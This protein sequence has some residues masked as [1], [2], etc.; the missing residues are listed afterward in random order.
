M[1]DVCLKFLKNRERLPSIDKIKAGY[2]LAF[3]EDRI[4][5][6]K[7]GNEWVIPKGEIRGGKL[8]KKAFKNN[9][10]E[11]YALSCEDAEPYIILDPKKSEGLDVFFISDSVDLNRE[12]SLKNGGE[13]LE[14]I[15]IE[16]ILFQPDIDGDK[17]LLWIL[18]QNARAK[19]GLN[20]W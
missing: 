12:K 11:K 13:T 2:L 6:V 19:L 3:Q 15:E 16:K 8:L 9:F 10:F 17:E 20:Y 4:L 5:S 18:I 7:D 14:F 1:K